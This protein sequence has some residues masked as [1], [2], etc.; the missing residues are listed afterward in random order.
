M[1]YNN[2]S[3]LEY[4]KEDKLFIQENEY[5]TKRLNK[6]KMYNE[7]PSKTRE[8]FNVKKIFKSKEL[9]KINKP[10]KHLIKKIKYGDDVD[11]KHFNIKNKKEDDMWIRPLH[12]DAFKLN[13]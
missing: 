4:N 13:N 3:K 10:L 7:F 9:F 11:L 12:K 8:E 6:T 1:K 2:T 5:I